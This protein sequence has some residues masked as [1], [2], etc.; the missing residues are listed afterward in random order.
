M[1][2]FNETWSVTSIKVA[3]GRFHNNFRVGYRAHLLGYMGFVLGIT[4][5]P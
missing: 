5:T 1:E 4:S 3:G 2:L